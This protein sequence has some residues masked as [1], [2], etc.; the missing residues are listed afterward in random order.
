MVS[1]STPQQ[2]ASFLAKDCLHSGSAVIDRV[3][4]GKVKEVSL[5]LHAAFLDCG[6]ADFEKYDFLIF[7]T[8]AIDT[9]DTAEAADNADVVYAQVTNIDGDT[10]HYEIVEKEYIEN[11]M[12]LFVTQRIDSEEAAASIDQEALLSRVEQQAVE[13]GFAEEAAN[14]MVQDAL[15]TEEVQIKLLNA[16]S[17]LCTS[18][19]RSRSSARIPPDQC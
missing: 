6:A 4:I 14:R 9:V 10:I 1:A 8:V 2:S 11:Y 15:K 16:G 12:D 17:L 18:S 13:S 19:P 5:T 3:C 7:Y